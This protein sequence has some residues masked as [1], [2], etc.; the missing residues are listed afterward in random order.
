MTA[1]LLLSTKRASRRSMSFR[2]TARRRA[3]IFYYAFD[4]L[5]LEVAM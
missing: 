2:I 5:V 3:A 4:V 1:R